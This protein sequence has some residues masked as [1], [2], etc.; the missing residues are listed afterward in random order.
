MNSATI[1]YMV[2]RVMGYKYPRELIETFL[3]LNPNDFYDVPAKYGYNGALSFGHI[4]VLY[5]GTPKMGICVEM[6]GQGC[7]EFCYQ[8]NSKNAL[9][10]LFHQLKNSDAVTRLDIAYDDYDRILN[11]NILSKKAAN[12]ELRTKM[13]TYTEIIENGG[14]SGH[15]LYFGAKDSNFRIRIYSK[16]TMSQTESQYH[17]QYIRVEEVLRHNIAHQFVKAYLIQ[18]KEE[19]SLSE[20][21]ELFLMMG[22]QLILKKLAF[23]ERTSKNISRCPVSEW[24][25]QFLGTANR[26]DSISLQHCL[27]IEK[28]DVW[29][30]ECVSQSLSALSLIYGPHWL[31]KTISYGINQNRRRNSRY[32]VLSSAY[33]AIGKKAK[34]ALTN[35]AEIDFLKS[36]LA[37][38]SYF[39]EEYEKERGDKIAKSSI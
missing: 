20:K 35:T 4:T 30:R 34:H 12:R 17:S 18:A 7:R 11:F 24:W 22:A 29:L 16:A 33:T 15:T 26:L 2:M 10:E 13:T 6:T 38:S 32:S 8:H 21:N 23:I 31:L 1:D 5:D 19:M 37:E 39:I 27:D 28:I 25:L 3:R 36:L 9:I 14:T